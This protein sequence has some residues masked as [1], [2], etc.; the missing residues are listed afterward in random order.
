MEDETEAAAA[1]LRT[2]RAAAPAEEAPYTT[3]A[4]WV[5]PDMVKNVLEARD[6]FA[7]RQRA[8]DGV[9]LQAAHEV[10]E[11]PDHMRLGVCFSL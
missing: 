7:E 5:T 11:T 2:A 9:L 6:A 1:A 4:T 10:R 8:L 3:G